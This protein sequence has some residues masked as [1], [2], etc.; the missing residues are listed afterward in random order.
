MR[1]TQYEQIS[2]SLPNLQ[3]VTDGCLFFKF[4]YSGY[5]TN[6]VIGPNLS[7]FVFNQFFE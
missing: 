5:Q 4:G 7:L 6:L 2:Q 1:N 3:C